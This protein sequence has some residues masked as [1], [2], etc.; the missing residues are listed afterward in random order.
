MNHIMHAYLIEGNDIQLIDRETIRIVNNH[1][2]KTMDL[3]L[4]KI[5]EVKEISNLLKL[6]S[7][8]HLTLILRDIDNLSLEAANAL[9]KTLEEPPKEVTF[10]LIAKSCYSVPPTIL[11]RCQVIRTLKT[12][13]VDEKDLN[14]FGTFLDSKISNKLSLATTFSGRAPAIEF[15]E[16]SILSAHKLLQEGKGEKGKIVNFL[17]KADTALA[18][19]RA[20][21]NVKL[22]LTNLFI[23]I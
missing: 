16:T 11:S 9:L 13:K 8:E 20:N 22:Q 7:S 3:V 23:G 10:I 5:E 1:K 6:S 21:G 17:T 12:K 18:A 2:G 14:E 15:L 4:H 19:I